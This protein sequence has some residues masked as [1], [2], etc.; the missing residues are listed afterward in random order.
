MSEA[1]RLRMQALVAKALGFSL[2]ALCIVPSALCADEEVIA[3]YD[4]AMS[5]YKAANYEQALKDLDQ[6]ETF[7]LEPSVRA[8]SLNLRAVILMR[9]ANY[10]AAESTLRS[11][12]ELVPFLA[13]AK[14][15]LGQVS[16]LKRDWPEARKR[17]EQ[18]LTE[19]YAAVGTDVCE[20]IRF[21]VFLTLLLDRKQGEAA[22]LMDQWQ[23]TSPAAYYAHVAMAKD[24]A[25]GTEARKWQQAAKTKF[26]EATDKLYAESF[27][28]IGW[29]ERASDQR[30]EKLEILTAAER[31]RRL[32]LGARDVL[33]K[34]ENTTVPGALKA[35]QRS[36]LSSGK[37]DMPEGKSAL[38]MLGLAL[39]I[40][41][42][43][44]TETEIPVCRALAAAPIFPQVSSSD[45]SKR[46]I[47][48]QQASQARAELEKLFAVADSPRSRQYILYKVFLTFILENSDSSAE[49]LMRRFSYTDETPVLYYARAAWAFQQEDFA[50]G[51]HWI[52]AATRIYSPELNALFLDDFYRLHWLDQNFDQISS[53]RI[54]LGPAL[55]NTLPVQLSGI[56]LA[57]PPAR[58]L[59]AVSEFVTGTEGSESPAR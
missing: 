12:L 49:S 31:D 32:E 57:A 21:K 59:D 45:H 37:K 44:F 51:K 28:E 48:S 43:Q 5:D 2:L 29:N 33:A 17:F 8:E 30:P 56:M 34:T 41:E 47:N 1:N 9:Q 6:L 16:F 54:S 50:S 4:Q 7:D 42:N 58:G 19:D 3:A 18:M 24:H 15:N 40:N 23:Q 55:S 26:G 53:T 13:N 10:Q 27:Y 25:D 11:A 52:E 20:L 38:E 36:P 46:T 22:K 14:F 39:S 35:A